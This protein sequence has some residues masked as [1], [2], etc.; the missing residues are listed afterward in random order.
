MNPMK[1]KRDYG[2]SSSRCSG[3]GVFYTAL[4]AHLHVDH[5]AK[6]IKMSLKEFHGISESILPTCP[7]FRQPDDLD[8]MPETCK[9]CG[10]VIDA[11]G[12]GCNPHD[13]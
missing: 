12:C 13:A 8:D 1:P 6:P 3:C 4:D 7:P 2:P 10:C 11:N 9:A 5:V